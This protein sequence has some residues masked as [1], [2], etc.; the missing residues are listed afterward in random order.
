MFNWKDT[1]PIELPLLNECIL[2]I[3]EACIEHQPPPLSF[4]S[5]TVN[6][7]RI[8]FKIYWGYLC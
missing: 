2:I 7:K 5:S 4:P 6:I 3:I 8:T 1:L